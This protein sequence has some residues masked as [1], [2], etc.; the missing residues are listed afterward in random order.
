MEIYN[1]LPTDIQETIAKQL[2]IDVNLQD[3]LRDIKYLQ[4]LLNMFIIPE[5]IDTHYNCSF[6]DALEEYEVERKVLT[7]AFMI[8]EK[9]DE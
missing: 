5:I 7:I 4:D 9:I 2:I 3:Q 8:E 6:Y 1:K